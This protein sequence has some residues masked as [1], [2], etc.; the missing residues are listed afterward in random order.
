M[1]IEHDLRDPN[2]ISLMQYKRR[3]PD[4]YSFAVVRNPWDRV[5]STYFFL[6]GG[7][8]KEEDREDAERFVSKYSSFNEFVLEAFNDKAILEQIHFRPQY[9]WLSDDNKLIVDQ[10]GRFEELQT[11][12][13]RWFRS[14]GL[15]NY[16]LPHVNKSGHDQYR[17]YY[18][19]D[20]A[21]IIRRAYSQ[22]VELFKYTF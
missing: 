19:D 18:T 22:D 3:K 12:C 1:V 7:G 9:K 14:V 13:T 21:A 17:T 10:V 2:H 4:I 6:M 16:T 15:P 20:T 5:V 8:I 11:H